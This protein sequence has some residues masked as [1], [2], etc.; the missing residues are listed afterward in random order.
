MRAEFVAIPDLLRSGMNQ[1]EIDERKHQLSLEAF[2][3]KLS[4]RMGVGS[5]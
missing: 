4:L 5:L 2:H 1:V 3:K